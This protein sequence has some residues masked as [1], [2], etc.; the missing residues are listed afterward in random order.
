MA[1]TYPIV[2]KSGWKLKGTDG[3]IP[4]I[5]MS[6]IDEM[7]EASYME[8]MKTKCEGVNVVTQIQ[9]NCTLNASQLK[10]SVIDGSSNI[11]TAITGTL[12]GTASKVKV[13]N[14]AVLL[15]DIS[16]KGSLQAM[17]SNSSSGASGTVL[18]QVWF[19]KAGQEKVKGI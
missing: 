3:V 12:Q 15:A 14:R 7:L 9:I 5:D 19:D 18:L 16:Q 1:V 11:C 4:S 17:W 10:T 6:F 8:D 2:V 13:G